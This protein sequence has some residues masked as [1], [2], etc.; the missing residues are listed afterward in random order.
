[1]S[2]GETPSA[3]SVSSAQSDR[4]RAKERLAKLKAD[5]GLEE[6][7]SLDERVAAGVPLW[8][9][10]RHPSGHEWAME[11]F[12]KIE[13]LVQEA[14]MNKSLTFRGKGIAAKYLQRIE[15]IL[16]AQGKP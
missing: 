13:K 14:R 7:D 10:T 5:K 1:M 6:T 3:Q 15:D 8:K 12:D 9:Q 11:V 4:E 16:G 2:T